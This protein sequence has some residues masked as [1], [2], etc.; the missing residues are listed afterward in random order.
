MKY[1]VYEV[2]QILYLRKLPEAF[3]DFYP[4]DAKIVI[5]ERYQKKTITH[6]ARSQ[7]HI[8]DDMQSPYYDP[9]DYYYYCSYSEDEDEYDM[10]TIPYLINY[11][12]KEDIDYFRELMEDTEEFYETHIQYLDT[13]DNC[14]GLQLYAPRIISHD[15]IHHTLPIF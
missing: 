5:K 8:L 6:R 14:L 4:E 1:P 12:T 3:R 15:P 10:L 11:I 7:L 2:G 9:E 13:I